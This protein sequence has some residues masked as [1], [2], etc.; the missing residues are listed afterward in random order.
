MY[1][2]AN[3][4]L[5]KISKLGVKKIFGVPGDFNLE[6]LDFILKNDKLDWVG[7]VNELNAAYCADGYARVNGVGVVVT[8]YGVGELSAINGIAGSYS[9]D[10]P[11]IHIVGVPPSFLVNSNKVVHHTLGNYKFDEFKKIYENVTCHQVWIDFINPIDQIN[12]AIQSCII[13]KKPIYIMLPTDVMKMEIGPINRDIYFPTI[14]DFESVNNVT[15]DLY[16]KIKNSKQAVIIAG[17]KITS[18][19]LKKYFNRFVNN[20]KISVVNTMYGK[21]SFDESNDFFA[22]IYI[23]KNT[24]DKQLQEF[25]DNADLI[26]SVGNKFTDLSSSNFQLGFNKE[27]MFIIDDKCVCYDGKQIDNILLNSVVKKLSN[28]EFNYDGINYKA[29]NILSKSVDPKDKITYDDFY[30]ILNSTISNDDIVVSDMGT[31]SFAAQYLN[32][33]ENTE[34]IMQPLYASIGF[35]LPASIGVKMAKWNSRVINIIGDGAF[36]MTL[37]EIATIVRNKIPMITFLIN[38]K[39]YT[40]ERVIHGPNEIYNDI[41]VIDYSKLLEGFDNKNRHILYFDILTNEDLLN[42]LI[43]ISD[44]DD[45]YIFVNVNIDP[46]DIPKSLKSVF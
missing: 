27:K 14:Y 1:T 13:Y 41:G 28:M 2:V 17:N 20:A 5:D 3:Y 40:I 26:I 30:S 38:N 43:K 35:S 29:K 36:N 16:N 25:V 11:I 6:F 45:K 46:L 42:C 10:I 8:T 32:L 19:R 7:S 18:Y 15:N 33:K 31:C 12:S 4:L 24:A 23:G 39:G 44:I 21:S 37:N 34:F 22:G 9:E